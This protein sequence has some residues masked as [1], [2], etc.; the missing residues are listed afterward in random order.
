MGVPSQRSVSRNPACT[1]VTSVACF[2]LALTVCPRR[3]SHH[4]VLVI[5]SDHFSLPTPLRTICIHDQ[6]LP[7]EAFSC[8]IVPSR[9]HKQCAGNAAAQ[10]ETGKREELQ[11]GGM[12]ERQREDGTL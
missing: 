8:F 3:R 2:H 12:A 11:C 1:P 5:Y 7:E 4:R 9:L 6:Q 10:W